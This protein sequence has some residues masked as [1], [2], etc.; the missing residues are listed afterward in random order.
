[1]DP[2]L[3]RPIVEADE[4]P[5]APW[6]VVIGHDVWR[7]RFASDPDVIGRELRLGNIHHTVVGVM[8]EGFRFPVAHSFWVPSGYRDAPQAG[9]RWRR[10]PSPSRW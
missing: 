9:R 3:G 6:V 4:Q 2:F 7:T 8:P 5:G 10:R 1:M